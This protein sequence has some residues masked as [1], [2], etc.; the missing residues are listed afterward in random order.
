MNERHLGKSGTECREL[1]NRNATSYTLPCLGTLGMQS[2]SSRYSR[3]YFNKW[4][5]NYMSFH[6]NVFPVFHSA[7]YFHRI[8]LM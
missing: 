4:V 6:P 7:F 8:Y 5:S 2:F 3:Y 1:C